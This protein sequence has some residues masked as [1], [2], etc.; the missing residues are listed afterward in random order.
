MLVWLLGQFAAGRQADLVGMPTAAR[1]LAAGW[2]CLLAM[3]LLAPRWLAWLAAHF[4]EPLKTPCAAVRALHREKEHTPTMGGLVIVAMV[5]AAMLVLADLSSGYV[6]AAICVLLGLAA[7]GGV[8][9][10]CK[11]RCR[12]NGLAPLV[13]LVLGLPPAGIAAWI[14]YAQHRAVPGGLDLW[15][16]WTGQ[17]DLG[18]WYPWLAVLVI[19]GLAHAVNLTDGLDGL[20]CGCALAV[21][22]CLA[23]VVWWGAVG[24]EILAAGPQNASASPKAAGFLGGKSTVGLAGLVPLRAGAETLVVTAAAIGTVAGFL[25]F[26]RHPARVFMGD[27]GA[28]SLGGLLAVLALANRLEWLLVIAG[29]VFLVEAASVVVQLVMRR[30]WGRRWLRCA[31]LHH[32]FE[33]AGWPETLVVRRF[34]IATALCVT[35]AV[36]LAIALCQ[37]P[38]ASAAVLAR[39]TALRR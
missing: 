24:A 5:L 22:G 34:W 8:D 20:A 31:P 10:L 27:T 18:S 14:I 15:L 30:V 6:Q 29:G 3:L 12:G 17:A 28:L 32:H 21:L 33:L 25:W 7:V 35:A 36:T 26:N 23:L 2:C 19:L 38:G 39:Q 16:P 37:K 13:K 4:R 9:D 1:A 11:L